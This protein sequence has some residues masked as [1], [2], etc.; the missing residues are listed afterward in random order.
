LSGIVTRYSRLGGPTWS[1]EG[2]A[3]VNT[4]VTH[5]LCTHRL[6]DSKMAENAPGH[7][8]QIW[9]CHPARERRTTDQ[10]GRGRRAMWAAPNL[11]QR[12]GAR[13]EK[14][15][16][17]QYRAYFEGLA[18][19]SVATLLRALARHTAPPA[20]SRPIKRCRFASDVL[21][22]IPV[23]KLL[24]WSSSPGAT[25]PKCDRTHIQGLWSP[26]HIGGW[27]NCPKSPLTFNSANS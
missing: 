9:P 19:L 10:S 6:H 13:S 24:Y 26:I 12:R 17:G 20:D 25:R 18:N 1:I 23:P 5:R 21:L 3:V 7:P 2:G 8:H 22:S 16:V 14:C 4:N 11:L 27:S 15:F